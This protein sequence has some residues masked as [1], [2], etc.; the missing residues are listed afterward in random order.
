MFLPRTNGFTT[1]VNVQV[2]PYIGTLEKYQLL[3]AKEFK[4]VKL[5]IIINKLTKNYLIF[6]Y[7]GKMPNSKRTLHWFSIAHQKN[8]KI[9]LVTATTTEKMWKNIQKYLFKM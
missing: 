8:N 3:S 4:Q 5:K 2:Q 1:N 6:E 7:M 9:Y